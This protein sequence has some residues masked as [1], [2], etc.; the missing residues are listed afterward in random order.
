MDGDLV[1]TGLSWSQMFGS[2]SDLEEGEKTEQ[3]GG[4]G[5]W[6]TEM[7]SERK[8]RKKKEEKRKEKKNM[9]VSN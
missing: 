5:K 3:R 9:Q 6:V 7:W 8:R 4:I 2:E 1:G